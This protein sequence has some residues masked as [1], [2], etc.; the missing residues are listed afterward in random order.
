MIDD[1]GNETPRFRVVR[2]ESGRYRVEDRD[3]GHFL[4]YSYSTP[5]LYGSPARPADEWGNYYSA[6]G[7][8]QKMA[9]RNT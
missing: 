3:N 5:P 4:R 8:C 2:A 6:R 9:A 1:F 7:F